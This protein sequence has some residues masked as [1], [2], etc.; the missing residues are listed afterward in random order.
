MKR[1]LAQLLVLFYCNFLFSQGNFSGP[2]K[3]TMIAGLKSG[4]SLVYYQCHVETVQQD[5]QTAGGQTLSTAPEKCSITEKYIVMNNNGTYRVKYYISSMVALP[6]RRFSGLKI[7]EKK[8]WNFKNLK[9]TTITENGVKLLAAIELKG[10]EP[11]EYDFA[12]TKYTTNQIII[13]K[14]KKFRQ[15]VIEGDHILSKLIFEK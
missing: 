13:K 4:D 1:K 5:L 8:Y 11:T 7:R 3:Q 2:M 14:G 12:I 9:D 10:K 15:L 6:N